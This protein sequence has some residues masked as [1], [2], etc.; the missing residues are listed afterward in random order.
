[1]NKRGHLSINEQ[2]PRIVE[3]LGLERLWQQ[4]PRLREQRRGPSA[5]ARRQTKTIICSTRMATRTPAWHSVSS[6]VDPSRWFPRSWRRPGFRAR[7]PI[8]SS[9][10]T[11]REI[12]QLT[13]CSVGDEGPSSPMHRSCLAPIPKEACERYR[14]VATPVV[15]LEDGL[16]PGRQ[17]SYAFKSG[18]GKL[19]AKRPGEP[20]P[21]MHASE[22]LS[23]F[24]ERA[25]SFRASA[26]RS[27]ALPRDIP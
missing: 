2:L 3:Q 20:I 24:A 22:S 23:P 7:K 9:S 4:L 13:A 17:R 10:I 1:M 14:L 25:V 5:S 16:I 19:S 15:R 8:C 12:L 6:S 26:E 18:S 21:E 11:S 27:W